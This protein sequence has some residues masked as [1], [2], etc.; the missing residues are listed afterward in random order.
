MHAHHAEIENV[1]CR[2][3][4]QSQQRH[5]HRNRSL[6][7]EH[8][9]FHFGAGDDD[10]VPRQNQRP[11]GLR[12]QVERFLI[13]ILIWREIGTI[14]AHLWSS[15]VPVEQSHGL[16]GIFGD[17]DQHRA[18]AS[19]FR[20]VERFANRRGHFIGAGHQIVV[21]GDGQGD[22]GDV[23]FLKGV[24]AQQLAAHLSGD[25]DDRNRIHHRGGDAG[26]HIGGAGARCSNRYAYSAGGAGVAVG[27]VG[28]ALFMPHQNV[29]DV[30]VL[31][32]VVRRQ[33]RAAGIAEN[34][35]HA[36]A[37]QAFPENS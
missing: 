24:G 10:A 18:G 11:L 37:L 28:C 36:F 20:D 6:L 30:A 1:R 5:R 34:R 3:S 27:H 8:L 12:D 35:L 19:G 21:L 9:H 29:V 2:E 33:N 25:A 17:V 14:A 13:F 22:A 16:L 23:G 15:R 32:R 26:H 31:E 4:A 7:R